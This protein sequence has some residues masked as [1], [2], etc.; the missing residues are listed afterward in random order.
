[1]ARSARARARRTATSTSTRATRAT[2]TTT[3]P[4]RSTPTARST[5]STCARDPKTSCAVTSEQL[6]ALI[7][8]PR[9]DAFALGRAVRDQ[10]AAI[11][12]LSAWRK[13]F[14]VVFDVLYGITQ[15]QH[16]VWV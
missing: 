1:M 4:G 15:T 13:D 12:V 5:R 11:A 3:R 6:D 10:K 9:E 8:A 2:S 16:L 7:A 14:G